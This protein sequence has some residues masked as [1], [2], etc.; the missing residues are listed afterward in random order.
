MQYLKVTLVQPD[1]IWEDQKA[2]LEKYDSLLEDA[3]KPDVV[4][5]PEM[6]NTGFS[7]K[8]PELAQPMD[9]KA[10]QWMANKANQLDAV[11][12]ASLIIEED[13]LY[14]NRLIWMEPGG[15]Y[16]TYDKRHLFSMTEEPK[17]FTPGQDKLVLSWKG[18]TICPMV[19]FDLRF[20]VWIRNVEEYDCF[21]VNANWP[22]RRSNHW[23]TFLQAR[24]V[25][26]QVY[27]IGVNRV[28]KDGND[29][30]FSGD[31]MV[32]DP[33]GEPRL[34]L[35]HSEQVTNFTMDYEEITKTRRYMPFLKEMDAFSWA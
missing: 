17:H 28:G 1:I 35:K 3:N 20:P 13:N 24:A 21:I 12:M 26:N 7:M 25:E 31:S 9:G 4:V 32:V 34:H 16:Q 19:C 27:T 6:F 23:R 8:A 22:D 10:V 14:Y 15:G 18:W 33:L 11:I 29:V 5:L 2:N 30:Y